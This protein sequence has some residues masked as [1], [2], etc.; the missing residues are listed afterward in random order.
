MGLVVYPVF[1]SP[2]PTPVPKASGEFVAEAFG[3]LD[4]LAADYDLTPLTAFA[5]QREIPE[6]FDGPP[7]KLAEI[8]GPCRDWYPARE[9][10]IAMEAFVRLIR[11]NAQAAAR[12]DAPSETATEL[13]DL[14]RILAAAEKTGGEF[15]LE[16]G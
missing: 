9:G 14:A 4:E 13:E 1:R 10:R 7:E 5:D 8:L 3:T 16:M 11:D 12:L 6:N 2:V 15:R